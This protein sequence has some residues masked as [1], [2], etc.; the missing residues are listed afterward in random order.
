MQQSQLGAQTSQPYLG[1]D[2][3]EALDGFGHA[4]PRHVKAAQELPRER[5]EAAAADRHAR[6]AGVSASRA[7]ETGGGGVVAGEQMQRAAGAPPVTP[8]AVRQQGTPL[9]QHMATTT[10]RLSRFFRRQRLIG[11]PWLG[12]LRTSGE[13]AHA[14]KKAAH[15]I[16]GGSASS[17]CCIAGTPKPAH[18]SHGS[19]G[20]EEGRG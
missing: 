14:A 19:D 2:Q 20:T 7:G 16:V 5:S 6:F 15:V 18:P 1:Q 9:D 17:G 13:V 8:V 11:V 12:E 3:R 4:L 10:H